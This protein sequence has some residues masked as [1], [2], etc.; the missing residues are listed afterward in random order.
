MV[1]MCTVGGNTFTVI[2]SAIS[3]LVFKVRRLGWGWDR[4]LL[5]CCEAQEA[6]T[7]GCRY[8]DI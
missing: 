4:R 8:S 5:P 1:M 6:P 2:S 3:Y 7:D